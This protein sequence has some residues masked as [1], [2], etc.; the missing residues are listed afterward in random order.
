MSE[1][2]QQATKL[3]EQTRATAEAAKAAGGKL[4]RLGG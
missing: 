1:T 2:K 4:A 3:E